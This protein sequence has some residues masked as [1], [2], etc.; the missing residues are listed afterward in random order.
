MSWKGRAWF[1]ASFLVLPIAADARD[2]EVHIRNPIAIDRPDSVVRIKLADLLPKTGS[3]PA[4]WE[5]TAAEM[6]VPSQV[7]DG[8]LVLL[9]DLGPNEERSVKIHPLPEGPAP[10]VISRT[11]ADLAIRVG[12]TEAH[13]EKGRV[14]Y[15]GGDFKTVETFT[16]AAE[17]WEHDGI[18]A[19]EGPGWES[20]RVA[21]RLYLDQRGVTD[22]F[23][24]RR[25][26]L[27]MHNVGRAADYHVM[28]DW[29]MDILHVGESLGAGSIGVLRGGSATQIGPSKAITATR[30]ADGPVISGFDLKTTQWILDGKTSDLTARYTIAAGSRLTEV[31]GQAARGLPMVAGIV[32]HDK[33]ETFQPKNPKARSWSYLATWGRQSLAGDD[34]LLGLAFFYPTA[35]VARTGDDGKSLYV[36]YADSAKPIRFA[37]G[38]A[39]PRELGGV[40]DKAAFQ[41][42]LEETADALSHP[43]QVTLSASRD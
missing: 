22:L 33:T 34:D 23:A 2:T 6:P 20:D 8:D 29:G 43:L 30:I 4:A 3:P 25:P 37:A 14:V 40:A 16:P 5:V 7:M 19:H 27:V 21:Y 24:K 41:R 13:D 10:R 31:T 39:W 12:A 28:A 36:L 11:Q 18:L 9:L 38:A 15:G 17:H 32:K 35:E 26:E 42:Y 1:L